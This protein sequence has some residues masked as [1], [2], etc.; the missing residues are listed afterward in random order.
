MTT[1]EQA[2][3]LLRQSEQLRND[4]DNYIRQTKEAL[5]DACHKYYAGEFVAKEAVK[6]LEKAFKQAEYAIK[7][8][9]EIQES[10]KRLID[11][12]I[13]LKKEYRIF[14]ICV[15]AIF[16]L[17]ILTTIADLIKHFL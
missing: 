4:I 15:G 2:E 10:C 16:I 13:A 6:S 3:M 8:Q 5:D 7:R 14:F 11:E 12:A 9:Q 1:N 17:Q